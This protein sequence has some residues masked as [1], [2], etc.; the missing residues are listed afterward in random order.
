MADSG[1]PEEGDKKPVLPKRPSWFKPVATNRRFPDEIRCAKAVPRAAEWIGT[2]NWFYAPGMDRTDEYRISSN[3]GGTHFL[4]WVGNRSEDDGSPEFAPV[5]YGPTKAKNGEVVDIRTAALHLLI[6]A[7]S[8]EKKEWDLQPPQES[9][10]IIDG[11]VLEA[12]C[13]EVWP[14]YWSRR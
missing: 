5:A 9:G 2:A 14:E 1:N 7:W 4:L 3:R 12:I 10:G 8:A 13:R 11:E 6:A